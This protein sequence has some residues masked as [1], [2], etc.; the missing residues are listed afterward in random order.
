ML[1]QPT[2]LT[3]PL[4]LNP[5]ECNS[6]LAGTQ[7]LMADGTTKSIDK[8]KPG[9]K[10]M[11]GQDAARS[12]S[13]TIDGQGDKDLITITTAD[14][15]SVTATDGHPIWTDDDGSA[16]TPG[17]R[18]VDAKD[19]RVGD[20]LKSSDGRLVKVAG[21]HALAQ[22]THAYNLTV[23][24]LHTYYVLAGS[25]PVLVHN[26]N[27]VCQGEENQTEY[28]SDDLSSFA[29]DYRIQRQIEDSRNIGVFDYSVNGVR[30]PLKAIVSR[31]QNLHSEKQFKDILEGLTKQGNT[32][33]VHRVYSEQNFC[34]VCGQMVDKRWADATHSWSFTADEA[35]VGRASA[36]LRRLFGG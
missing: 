23:D 34:D 10:V 14:G 26:S 30:Q 6:F 35:A 21:L 31:G 5:E 20:W 17:G 11:A 12:V 16:T 28:D 29:L 22:H 13:A 19:L 36:V 24:D 4:G 7:V 15:G 25:T 8:I 2:G 18:W 3:D 9:D 32:V 33:K 1:N 27:F